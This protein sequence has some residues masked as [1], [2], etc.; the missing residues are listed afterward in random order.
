METISPGAEGSVKEASEV[1]CVQLARGNVMDN[2]ELPIH[3]VM[4][5]RERKREREGGGGGR[6]K[7]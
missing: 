3:V 2:F 4:P 1:Q 5:V 7:M 6:R